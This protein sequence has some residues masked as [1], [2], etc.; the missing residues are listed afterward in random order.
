MA[1][2]TP[3]S[4]DAALA[5]YEE[6][7]HVEEALQA[8]APQE[9]K[10]NQN[11]L[12]RAMGGAAVV[13]GVAGLVLMGPVVGLV[14]AAGGAALATTKGK[15]G[16]VTRAT[17]EAVASAGGRLKELDKKHKISDKAAKAAVKGA[18]WASN[19]LQVKK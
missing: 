7:Y 14:A 8:T 3:A 11:S 13:G 15:A 2:T 4:P 10:D 18:N 5:P 9:V 16:D 1:A 17:G 6:E 12:N 19:K